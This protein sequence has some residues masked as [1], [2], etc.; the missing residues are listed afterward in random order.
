MTTTI[1]IQNKLLNLGR[2]S[3]YMLCLLHQTNTPD[4]QILEL[5][6]YFIKKGFMDEECFKIVMV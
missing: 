1:D 3:C 2:Y 6:D 5:Y 4:S